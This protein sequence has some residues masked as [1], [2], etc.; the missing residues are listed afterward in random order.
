MTTASKWANYDVAR[1]RLLMQIGELNHLIDQEQSA[2]VP[3]AAKIAALENQQSALIYQSDILSA[4]DLV[5][6]SR[7][8]SPDWTGQ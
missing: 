5:L 4:D 6:T 2:A 3:N 8:A 1:S 7:I